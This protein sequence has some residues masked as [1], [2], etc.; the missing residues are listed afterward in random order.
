M[1]G[2]GPFHYLANHQ[3]LL[4]QGQRK[5]RDLNPQGLSH[6]ARFRTE[7]LIQPD[8]FHRIDKL[9]KFQ[10]P[11]DSNHYLPPPRAGVLPH[12][13][14]SISASSD[15]GSYQSTILLRSFKRSAL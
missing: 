15:A 10:W 8:A 7:F 4:L 13:T 12:Y 5:A 6:P 3:W 9:Q 2:V 1:H 11:V 14:R